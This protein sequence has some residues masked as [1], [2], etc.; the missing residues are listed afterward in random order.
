MDLQLP[1]LNTQHSCKRTMQAAAAYYLPLCI[2][3]V[4][5]CNKRINNTGYA[6]YTLPTAVHA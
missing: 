3:G 6:S 1:M 5:L 4:T 2:P